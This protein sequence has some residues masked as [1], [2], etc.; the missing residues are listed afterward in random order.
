MI[1]IQTLDSSL[2]TAL[3]RLKSDSSLSLG[4]VASINLTKVEVN[5][6]SIK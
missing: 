4:Q 3:C 2:I 6:S 1:V 5:S